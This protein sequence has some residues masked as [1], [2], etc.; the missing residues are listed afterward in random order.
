[1]SH[2][3][4][5]RSQARSAQHNGDFR[6]AQSLLERILQQDGGDSESWFLHG[7]VAQ[8]Q[9]K[10][11]E[12]VASMQH[13]IRLRPQ[14]AEAYFALAG[15]FADQGRRDDVIATYRQ[16][17]QIDPAHPDALVGLGVALAEKG[18]LDEAVIYLRE[19]TR[20]RPDFAKA[21][22]NLGV[23]LAQQ[24]KPEDAAAALRQAL[25][26]KPDYA[27]ACYNL[28]NVL[29]GLAQT[30]DSIAY[31]HRALDLKPDYGDVCIN[32]GLARTETGR[33]HES[34]ILLQHAVRLQ[35]KSTL[36]HNNLGL[37][38]TE[39]LRFAE[40]EGSFH[41]A[42]RTEPMNLDV[43]NNLGNLYKAQG[44]MAEAVACYDMG[45]RIQPDSASTHWN[46]AL[47]WLEMGDFQRGWP[48]Y[49][50]RW[51]RPQTP[52]R[53]FP[54]PRWDGSPLEGQTILL[55]MEQGLGD[56]IQFIRY[57]ALL[58]Q[59]GGR[60]IV[61]C[62][63]SLHCLFAT[64]PGI[65][66]VVVEGQPLPNFTIQVP[67]LSLPG[68][69][70]TTLATIPAEVPYLRADPERIAKWRAELGPIVGFKI[71]LVWQGNPKHGA[72]RHR[73]L[74]L[75]VFAPLAAVEGVRL[76]SLQKGPGTEQIPDAR[77][78]LAVLDL[79]SETWNDFMETAAVIA[80]L[81]LVVTVD[82]AVA[83]LAGALGAPVWVALP[84]AL[85]WRWLLKRD[86]SPWY[87][88]MRLFRQP[89]PGDWSPVI[90]R[91]ADALRHH[92]AGQSAER[93]IRI[94]I[95]PGELLDR[96]A[97]LE[98]QGEETPDGQKLPH[99]ADELESLRRLAQDGVSWSPELRKLE[100]QLK[101]VRETL[102]RAETALRAAVDESSTDQL[103]HEA[104][105]VSDARQ[106][107]AELIKQINALAA[108]GRSWPPALTSPKREGPLG[109]TPEG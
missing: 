66:Q 64:C 57:A 29:K 60:V 14:A 3:N 31:Y 79:R 106:Q 94:T 16:F 67:L 4:D 71:G 75:Q 9:G 35:P 18:V 88:T 24:G 85:D 56:M 80:N 86:D 47:A 50:W 89:A 26:L 46:R 51:R 22:H 54:Q 100:S 21:H 58:K 107:H 34:V 13:A 10:L 33:L 97:S 74:P 52:P 82:T 41:Q 78:K 12:A 11:S 61:E 65:D 95:T 55:Y 90:E 2:Q 81:D 38:L 42:L 63:P 98:I 5:L 28:G 25:Q 69:L 77:P 96:I 108:T 44:R 73:S 20:L 76:V 8:R 6:Q 72:D 102:H 101:T 84:H 62:P 59:R 30:E 99:H 83:H 40:A 1:M 109:A 105:A 7:A 39:L 70:D 32:L 19:A 49:E 15:V 17:L 27:E 68:L 48:E 53:P 37:A 87:P 93:L 23:A 92:L 104:R 36:A 45:L 103:R 43:H 91:M